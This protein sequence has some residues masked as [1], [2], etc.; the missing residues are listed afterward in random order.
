MKVCFKMCLQIT[1]LKGGLSHAGCQLNSIM[2]VWK[3]PPNTHTQAHTYM[4]T[5][6][7]TPTQSTAIPL[8]SYFQSNKYCL[9]ASQ[10]SRLVSWF[11]HSAF[12]ENGWAESCSSKLHMLKSYA[13]APQNMTIFGVG[14]S[15]T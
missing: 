7:H 10:T 1:D 6:T 13:K 4:H 15:E 9:Q 5:C 11:L 3:E 8:F 12:K 14:S 2:L